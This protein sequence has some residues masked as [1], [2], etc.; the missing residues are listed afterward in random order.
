MTELYNF[1]KSFIQPIFGGF[2]E[3]T[4][5]FPMLH[6]AMMA[7]SYLMDGAVSLSVVGLVGV[8]SFRL[9]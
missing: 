5:G 9:W 6:N 7:T 3:L 2:F 4:V 8:I 1:S